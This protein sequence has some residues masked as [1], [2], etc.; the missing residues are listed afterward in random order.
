M[1][2]QQPSRA[3][4]IQ[5]SPQVQAQRRVI[6]RVFGDSARRPGAAGRP[7]EPLQ[8][9]RIPGL[10]QGARQDEPAQ[11]PEPRKGGRGDKGAKSS[12]KK[13]SKSKK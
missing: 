4:A 2:H 6:Q 3:A 10:P 9:K 12:G 7:G 8:A 11:Q 5:D 13:S 1:E